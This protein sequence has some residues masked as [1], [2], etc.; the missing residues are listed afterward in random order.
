MISE[1][2][3]GQPPATGQF[4]A[5]NRLLAGL[6]LGVLVVE[7]TKRSGSLITARLAGEQGRS[8]FAIPGSIH[9][10]LARGCHQLIR[11]GALLVESGEDL[12]L[13]L[14]PRLADA[15][16]RPQA[17]PSESPVAAVKQDLDHDHRVLLEAMAWDPVSID[18]LVQRTSLTAAEVSSM[19]LIMELEGKVESLPGGG[20][21]RCR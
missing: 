4:P 17:R 1:Y 10:P 12:L 13:E 7:A 5:R 8:V 6:S 18:E 2:L 3:P 15:D 14:G 16:A 9:N 11:Q 20:F 19:L 21:A